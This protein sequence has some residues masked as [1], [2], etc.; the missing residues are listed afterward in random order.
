MSSLPNMYFKQQQIFL[1]LRAVQSNG[2]TLM[3]DIGTTFQPPSS[4]IVFN[5]LAPL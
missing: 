2:K 4:S 1:L 3:L 5:L